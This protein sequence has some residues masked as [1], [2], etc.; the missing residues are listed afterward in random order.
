M[1]AGRAARPRPPHP[2]NPA[3][4]PRRAGRGPGRPPLPAPR[5]RRNAW[6][7]RPGAILSG[8]GAAQPRCFRLFPGPRPALRQPG[9]S[10][11]RGVGGGVTWR[12]GKG[13]AAAIRLGLRPR[14][15]PGRRPAAVRTCALGR[16]RAA[17]LLIARLAR[18]AAPGRPLPVR[19]SSGEHRRP[20]HSLP[21][22]GLRPHWIAPL[23]ASGQS[24]ASISL[25]VNWGCA[26][27]LYMVGTK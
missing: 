21:S 2:S 26:T 19:P 14:P 8:R 13:K 24:P 15:R 17:G 4:Q 27:W 25:P 5:A 16:G 18:A 20:G 3:R 7:P 23:C 9:L 12:G 22:G 10:A 11:A 6:Q 1:P